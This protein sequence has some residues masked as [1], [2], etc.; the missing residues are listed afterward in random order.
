LPKAKTAILGI[1][2]DPVVGNMFEGKVARILDFGAIIEIFPGKD[3]LLHVSRLAKGMTMKSLSIGQ[4]IMVKLF[5]IDQQGRLNFSM[6]PD[7]EDDGGESRGG[8][9]G[10]GRKDGYKHVRTDKGN[11]KP[12]NR[13]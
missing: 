9:H 8:S 1:A 2:T 6:N 5:S 12:Y 13:Y 11:K 3:G 4:K 7:E 10:G